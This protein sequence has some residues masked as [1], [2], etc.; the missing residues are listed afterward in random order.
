VPALFR[1]D[2]DLPALARKVREE[3][4]RLARTVNH[5]QRPAHYDETSGD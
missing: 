5:P 1:P 4:T 3:V 2:L